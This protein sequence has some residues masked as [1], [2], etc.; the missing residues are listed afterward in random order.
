VKL[1]VN[2]LWRGVTIPVTIIAP[3]QSDASLFKSSAPNCL[4]RASIQRMRGVRYGQ[5][6]KLRKSKWDMGEIK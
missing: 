3:S 1:C 4:F 2:V 5:G 6:L